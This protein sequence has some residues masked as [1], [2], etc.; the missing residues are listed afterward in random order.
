MDALQEARDYLNQYQYRIN[1]DSYRGDLESR[2]RYENAA[3]QEGM[4]QAAIAQAEQLTR[5]AD[6][7]DRYVGP[8]KVDPLADYHANGL[9]GESLG[10]YNARIVPA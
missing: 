10:E 7:L 1:Q 6:I 5:I 4:L 3:Y 8:E 2:T 9:P